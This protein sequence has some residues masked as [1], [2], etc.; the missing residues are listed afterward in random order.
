MHQIKTAVPTY[1]R[2]GQSLEG[3]DSGGCNTLFQDWEAQVRKNL[4]SPQCF[5]S[6]FIKHHLHCCTNN[7]T[8]LGDELSWNKP[9]AKPSAALP[10]PMLRE[11][12]QCAATALS[13]AAHSAPRRHLIW[14]LSSL[15]IFFNLAVSQIS[16]EH[17]AFQQRHHQRQPVTHQPA[18]ESSRA[19]THGEHGH[20]QPERRSHWSQAMAPV[21]PF[22]PL[23]TATDSLLKP[24]V[25][26]QNWYLCCKTLSVQFA[27]F[28]LG[29]IF[30][31]SGHWP[32]LICLQGST[33]KTGRK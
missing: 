14:N 7:S 23:L 28:C 33:R 6:W 32:C 10:A 4:H 30:S 2:T 27:M 11:R 22:C 13:Q 24:Q 29:C 18:P 19:D 9:S 16:S 8:L 1:H 15:F 3:H 17:S 26:L 25:K 31:F 5:P 20:G 12:G 21:P